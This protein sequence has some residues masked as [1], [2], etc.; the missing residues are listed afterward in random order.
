MERALLP[1]ISLFCTK[2]G[3]DKEYHAEIKE[4]EGGYIVQTRFGKRGAA[5]EPKTTPSVMRFADAMDAF[6]SLIKEKTRTQKG[7]TPAVDG[8]GYATSEQAGKMSGNMP[9]LLV[10]ISKENLDSLINDD[11]YGFQEKINGERLMV[12]RT[13]DLVTTS[14]KLGVINSVPSSIVDAIRDLEDEDLVLDGESLDSK[15][16]VFDLIRANGKCLK[17]TSAIERYK[18]YNDMDF[19]SSLI[20]VPMVIGTDAKRAMVSHAIKENGVNLIEGIVAKLLDAPYVSGRAAPSI[21]TQ[22]KYKFV[23]D[24][25]CIVLS[26]DGSKRSVQIGLIN[27]S[28]VQPVGNVGVPTNHLMPCEGDVIDVQY[29]HLF[30]GG[31]LCEPVFLKHRNDVGTNE[32]SFAQINRIKVNRLKSN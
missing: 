31:A 22:F 15:M 5:K 25:S 10:S 21:A 30:D 17:L 27:G 1:K 12:Q 9:H 14:N 11:R 8:I 23:E 16:Y 20:K 18:L 13:A 29:R 2:D 26:R 19:G 3:S 24:A 32:C 7:Y 6:D 28:S 4:V